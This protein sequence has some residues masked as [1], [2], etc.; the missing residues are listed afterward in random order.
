MVAP[1]QAAQ[2]KGRG[3][4]VPS[5]TRGLSYRVWPQSNALRIRHR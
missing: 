2:C 5:K 3:G 1:P 4:T